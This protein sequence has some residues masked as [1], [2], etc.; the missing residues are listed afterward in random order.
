MPIFEIVFDFPQ[1]NLFLLLPLLLLL[2]LLLLQGF[3]PAVP[4]GAIP[5]TGDDSVHRDGK[6]RELRRRVSV[7]AEPEERIRQMQT[8]LEEARGDP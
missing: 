1:A 6:G 3:G 4:G 2:L 7:A 5:P 8:R